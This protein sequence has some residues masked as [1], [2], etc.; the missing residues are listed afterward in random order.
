[1]SIASLALRLAAKR[2]LDGATIAGSKVYDSAISSLDDLVKDQPQPIITISTED[3]RVS[4]TGRDVLAG[5]RSLNLVIEIALASSATNS[6]SEGAVEATIV[7]PASDAGLELS[8]SLMERQAM[9]ALF[10]GAGP[11]AD[12]FAR[13]A[14]QVGGIRSRRGASAEGTRFAARQ[15]ILTIEPLA[16]PAF[17]RPS[18]EHQMCAAFVAAL[19]SDPEFAALMPSMRSAIEGEQ[20]ADWRALATALGL[21]DREARGIGIFPAIDPAEEPA[22]L[23]GMEVEGG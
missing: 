19:E 14:P 9:A 8:L 3:E 18:T 2:L 1:M 22:V 20:I 21:T 7:I 15:I 11:W 10:A 5:K 6:I 4:P 13:A 12:V 23:A 17:G 16:D